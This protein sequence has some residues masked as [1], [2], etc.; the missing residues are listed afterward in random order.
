MSLSPPAYRFMTPDH[1]AT[2]LSA[3]LGASRVLGADDGTEVEGAVASPTA[4]A[5]Q[6]GRI[7]AVD[8]HGVLQLDGG[9]GPRVGGVRRLIVD[10]EVLWV[11]GTGALTQFDRDSLQALTTVDGSGVKDVAPDGRDGLYRLDGA[12]VWRLDALGRPTDERFALPKGRVAT[13]VA[14]VG[15]RLAL[16]AAD[17]SALW[18]MT[19]EGGPAGE[20]MV[21]RALRR[22]GVKG[23][24]TARTLVGG[25]DLLLVLGTWSE[26]RRSGLLAFDRKGALVGVVEWRGPGPDAVTLGDDGLLA[27]FGDRLFR[28]STAWLQA[29]EVRLTPP[30]DTETPAGGWLHGDV[31]AVVPEGAVLSLR[32]AATGDG[33]QIAALT[34]IHHDAGLT[35]AVR[36]ATITDRLEW[37]GPFV[38]EGGPDPGSDPGQP[39]PAERFPLLLHPAPMGSSVWVKIRLETHDA[40]RAGEIRSLVVTHD[41]DGLAASLPA[42]YRGHGDPDGALRRLVGVLEA[43][44]QDIDDRIGHLASRLDTDRTSDVWLPALAEVLGLPFDDA[45]DADMRR[46][47]VK[48]AP[49]LL[50]HRGTRTGVLTL[51]RA[52]F[53]DRP[54]RLEDRAADLLPATTGATALPAWLSGPSMRTPRLNAR[55]VLGRTGLPCA[56]SGCVDGLLTP[57]PEVVVTVPATARERRLYEAAVRQMIEA[58]LP[59]GLR[60]RLRWSAWHGQFGRLA[61]DV[62]T[63]VSAPEPMRLDRGQALGDARIGDRNLP[64]I[65]PDGLTPVGHRLL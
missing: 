8:G 50:Q 63:V 59:A 27:A 14:P 26:D 3:G 60:L 54:F 41:A 62:I 15:T 39:A 1:W 56:T 18:L 11:L 9:C 19:R 35:E 51:L 61:D 30:L 17:G 12:S 4:L 13:S 2:A 49:D 31:E 57:G 29:G 38:Y 28:F 40:R 44:T 42:I 23:T 22:L 20:I 6:D 21:E 36:I 24:F 47:L 64:R 5:A 7:W 52:L 32:W 34:R 65:A 46:R 53:E 33:E 48:A 10:R 45:L 43:T 25:A 37:H 55:L 58:V 16:L